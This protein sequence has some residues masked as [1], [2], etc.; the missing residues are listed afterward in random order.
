[1]KHDVTVVICAH[2]T[3][4]WQ[5]L[6]EAVSSLQRQ[7]L[8]PAE[9]VVVIDHNAELAQRARAA[10]SAT[11]VVENK[12]AK[13]LC[14]AR[15][16]GLDAASGSI[17]A[18]MDDDATASER[19]LELLVA[20]YSDQEVAGVGGATLP[21]WESGRPPWFPPEFDWVVGGPYRGMRLVKQEVRNLWGG[22]MSFRRDLV[23]AIGGFRI[24]YS[25][26]D[27]ELCIRLRQ[28]WPE[29]RFVFVPDAQVLHHIDSSRTSVRQFLVRCYF[30]GGSKAVISRL[31][32]ADEALES[33]RRYT[34]TVIPSGIGRSLR[35]LVMNRDPNGAVRAG[36]IMGGFGSAATGYAV[37]LV[38]LDRSARRRGW[39]GGKLTRRRTAQRA[40][41]SLGRGWRRTHGGQ[42]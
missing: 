34:R 30:E 25:C 2:D 29:K 14:G 11:V 22:N 19:W 35:E 41:R 7:T 42:D 1:M 21:V 26:D 37:G 33:E 20:E 27:T 9:V 3:S 4:R 13:G 12:G 18:F 10:L 36:L 24:G 32:G 28:R 6:G 17:V 5:R 16:S 31:V 40:S 23:T 39:Q 8:S 38:T 15:N